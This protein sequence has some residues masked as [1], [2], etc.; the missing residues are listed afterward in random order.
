MNK[1]SY[2]YLVLFSICFLSTAISA[3][4]PIYRSPCALAVSNDGKTLFA[5]ESTAKQ[6]SVIELTTNEIVNTIP[7]PSTPTGMALLENGSTLYVTCANPSGSVYVIDIQSM[8][9]TQTQPAGHGAC[10]PVIDEENNILYICNRFDN[11]ISFIDLQTKQEVARIAV[12]REPIDA[13]L[14][15]GGDYLFIVNHQ[16]VGRSDA[17]YISAAVSIIDTN[18]QEVVKG[19]SLPN[20][21][22]S[23]RGMC[24]SPDGEYIYFTHLLARYQMPTF[25]LDR[26]WM[27]T[28]AMSIIDVGKQ[29]LLNTV[30]L[31][32]VDSGAANPWGI[33]CTEDSQYIC[34]AHAGT[35]EISIIDAQAL[36]KK[37]KALPITTSNLES[38]DYMPSIQTADDVPNDLSFLVDIRERISLKE[39]GPRALAIAGN[40]V[41]TANYFSGSISVVDIYAKRKKEAVIS[42]GK[43]QPL[44][45]E[46][47]GEL[48]FRDA[49]LCF[50]QWQSCS[51]CHPGSRS[52]SLNW[53]LLNDGVGNPKNTKSLLLAHETP[54]AMSLGVRGGAE[55]AVRSGITHILFLERPEE[56]AVA[57]DHYL[58]SMKPVPSPHLVN[59][60]LSDKAQ[61]GKEIFYSDEA[62]CAKCHT[63]PHYTDLQSYN[64][65]TKGKYDRKDTFDTPTLIEIWR[66]APYLHDG[67]AATLMDVLTTCN[68]S[69]QHGKT[70]HLS[71]EE[72]EGLEEFLLSL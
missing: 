36:L 34:V 48:N 35:H 49:T 33:A 41:Y 20:G 2:L 3:G 6:I 72:L 16:P 71:G 63:G 53:D 26:G 7:L 15:P 65:G 44:T 22:V 39:K 11:D 69:D 56:D 5:A 46:R 12:S 40:K 42:L 24:I 57:I 52:D 58:K 23:L 30:L 1:N 50:Q 43:E 61:R 8:Q 13:V 32:D 70:S 19:I 45:L 10:A 55:V 17:D 14:T 18:K 59:G 9:I 47:Q 54:P 51:S 29:S 68:P 62:A 67:Q 60:E 27:N 31:D 28:N 4:E 37:L 21:S 66:T 64:V 38:T 25:Q